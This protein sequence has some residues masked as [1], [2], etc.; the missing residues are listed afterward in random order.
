MLGEQNLQ[1]SQCGASNPVTFW[2]FEKAPGINRV[3]RAPSLKN[4]PPRF[5]LVLSASG[6]LGRRA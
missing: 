6:F 2:R 5:A 3:S 1:C 4:K